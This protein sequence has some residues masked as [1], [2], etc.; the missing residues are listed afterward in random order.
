MPDTPHRQCCS[1]A[2]LNRVWHTLG[3]LP[4]I[5]TL[6]A[7]EAASAE[8]VAYDIDPHHTYPSF[9][10]DHMG[11]SVWRGKLDKTTGHVMLDKAAGRGTVELTVDLASIDFGLNE[12]NSWAQGPQ[13][14]DI[15]Q[16]P[17]ATYRGTLEGFSGGVPSRVV[18][19]LSLHGVTRPVVLHINS[20]KCIAHP[21]LKRDMCGADAIASFQ[22][23]AFGLTAGKDY[24]LKMDVVLRIQVEAVA[25]P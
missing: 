9:E 17:I 11:V 23:D 4:L 15:K 14:F 21:M 16:N 18:G 25:V 20:F 22:R 7:A 6:L 19:E 8:P 12:L 10:A 3:I 13:F 24:G 2:H 1:R 5:L